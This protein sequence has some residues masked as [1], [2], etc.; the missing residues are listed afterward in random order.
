MEKH[1]A[2]INPKSDSIV[3]EI[4]NPDVDFSQLVKEH[5]GRDT[6]PEDQVSIISENGIAKAANL[7]D[8]ISDYFETRNVE[9]EGVPRRYKCLEMEVK[10]KVDFWQYCKN[11]SCLIANKQIFEIRKTR[12]NSIGDLRLFGETFYISEK[13]PSTE[14]IMDEEILGDLISMN[15]F[16]YRGNLYELDEEEGEIKLNGKHYRISN[17]KR[18]QAIKCESLAPKTKVTKEVIY[19]EMTKIIIRRTYTK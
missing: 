14:I 7:E 2:I 5:L 19:K 11:T 12:E 9:I 16:N 1:I 3:K 13:S 18:G 15:Y 6:R 8:K 4:N 17:R 10:Q